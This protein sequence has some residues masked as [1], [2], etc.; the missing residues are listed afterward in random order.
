MTI[1]AL[2]HGNDEWQVGGW[3]I[4]DSD[5]VPR[6]DL[7]KTTLCSHALTSLSKDFHVTFSIFTHVFVKADP[8]RKRSEAM[9]EILILLFSAVWT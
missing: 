9:L 5:T 4:T 6:A 7:W 3:P 2:C 8:I 1:S